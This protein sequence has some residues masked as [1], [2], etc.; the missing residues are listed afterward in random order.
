MRVLAISHQ[1]DAGPGVFADAVRAAG[2]ELDLWHRAEAD[3]PAS[4][5][6]TYDA[7]MAFGGSMHADQEGR[8]PWLAAEKTLLRELLDRATP[9]LG[10]CLGSQLLC[11]AAGGTA[12]PARRPEIGWVEVELTAAARGD[13]LLDVLA[14]RFEAFQWHGYEARPPAG[15]TTLARSDVCPQAFRLGG[16]AWGIQF[17]AEVSAA[18]AGRW[19]DE[20]DGGAGGV[21]RSALRAE[22]EAKIGVWNELGRALCRRWLEAAAR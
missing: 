22:T 10:V 3:A 14:P 21:D 6:L 5:P 4:D 7:V 8:H 20:H 12:V 1:R 9:L 13:P 18:D 11:E 19:I 15:A 16:R 17:H 2:A